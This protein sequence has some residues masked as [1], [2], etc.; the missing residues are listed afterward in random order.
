MSWTKYYPAH[1]AA[2]L[3]RFSSVNR[4]LRAGEFEEALEAAK[5]AG[6]WRLDIRWRNVKPR[7]RPVW[8]PW[9]REASRKHALIVMKSL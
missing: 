6:L 8:L 1:E 5:V 3:P 2:T 4:H 7:G 9:M